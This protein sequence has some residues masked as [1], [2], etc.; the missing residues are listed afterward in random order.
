MATLP[1]HAAPTET[2]LARGPG[3][4]NT[5]RQCV[6]SAGWGCRATAIGCTLRARRNWRIT[7]SSARTVLGAGLQGLR[8]RALPW[9][10][11]LPHAPGGL[12]SPAGSL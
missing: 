4:V 12:L 2:L 11:R 5:A 8:G 9:T 1:D 6:W 3:L 7:E 10:D